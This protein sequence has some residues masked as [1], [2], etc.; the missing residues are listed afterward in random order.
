MSISQQS[1]NYEGLYSPEHTID[2]SQYTGIYEN[3]DL[4]FL[5]DEEEEKVDI[6]TPPNKDHTQLIGAVKSNA[7]VRINSIYNARFDKVA[8]AKSFYRAKI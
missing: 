3:K 7:L 8:Q 1:P 6:Q 2:H 5:D 4:E